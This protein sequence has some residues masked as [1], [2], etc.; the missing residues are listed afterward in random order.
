MSISVEAGG[1]QA[2]SGATLDLMAQALLQ[3]RQRRGQ[4]DIDFVDDADAAIRALAAAGYVIVPRAPTEAMLNA[5]VFPVDEQF[6]V[7]LTV[8]AQAW[9]AMVEAALK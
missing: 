6:D 9:R 5:G 2:Q 4:G 8:L 7:S 1:K 3:A